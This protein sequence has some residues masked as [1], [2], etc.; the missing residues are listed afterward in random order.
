MELRA[1]QKM[2]APLSRRARLMI[3]RGI[4]NLVYDGLKAQG[5]QVSLLSGEVRDLVERFQEYGFTSV[6]HAGAEAVMVSVGGNRDHG[7]VIAC[8]DRR[9]RLKG[10]SAGEVALY[11]DEGDKIVLKRGRIVEMT[12]KNLVINA[13]E[14][15][16]I[17]SPVINAS[18][19]FNADGDVADGVR[20]MSADRTIYNSHTHPETGTTTGVPNQQE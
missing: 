20:A 15:V 12:T 3:G 4:I 11:T 5:V 1:L 13:E 16:T 7:I 14:A 8:E 18:G 6:P 17:N 9:Y 10:L 19:D 2:I